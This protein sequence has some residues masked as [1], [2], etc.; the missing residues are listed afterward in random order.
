MNY[1]E[2]DK[3]QILR[4]SII[5]LVAVYEVICHCYRGSNDEIIRIISARKATKN[6]TRIYISGGAEE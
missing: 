5:K 3:K 2:H 4:N 6:E 1:Y